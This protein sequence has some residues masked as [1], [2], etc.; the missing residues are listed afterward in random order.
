[1]GTA[2]LDPTVQANDP[3]A[4]LFRVNLLLERLALGS[5]ANSMARIQEMPGFPSLT[6]E[7]QGNFVTP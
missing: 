6:G 5:A 7:P 2:G 1:M 3:R 4:N